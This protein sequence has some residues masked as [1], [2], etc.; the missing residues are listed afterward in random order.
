MNLKLTI[1]KN[2]IRIV[3]LIILILGIAIM[4]Y[5]D[6]DLASF[7]SG[8]LI[9]IGAIMLLLGRIGKISDY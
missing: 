9:G 2:K 8:M 6:H 5:V 4:Q 1:S 7:F 3:G